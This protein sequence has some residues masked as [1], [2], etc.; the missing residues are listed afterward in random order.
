[1]KLHLELYN[2]KDERAGYAL[3]ELQAEELHVSWIYV[4]PSE[5]GRGVG[6][7][8]MKL[9]VD[10]ARRRGLSKVTGF[11]DTHGEDVKAR[12]QFFKRLAEVHYVNGSL[13]FTIYTNSLI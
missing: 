8:L 13:R 4:H 12:I 3:L 9:T 7:R 5:R 10:Y 6:S 11:I 1:M 2:E